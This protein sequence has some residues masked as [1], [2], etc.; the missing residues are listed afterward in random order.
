M[1]MQSVAYKCPNCAAPLEYNNE[2]GG[3]K[4]LFCES[5]F[6]EDEIKERFAQNE[7]IKLD[8]ADPSLTDE[9]KEIEEFTGA[10]ALYSCPNCGASVICGELDA[11]V[12]CHFCHTPVILT[13][14]LSGEYKPDLII[15]F[16]TNRQLAEIS[17]KK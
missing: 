1:E 9:Q 13:G 4:C 17:F 2:V 16:K 15:P 7:Q 3:F 11:S 8:K 10:S 12:R 6:K 5:I 14:R